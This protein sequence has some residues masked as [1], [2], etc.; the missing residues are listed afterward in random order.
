[1]KDLS[2]PGRIVTALA[3]IIFLASII[4]LADNNSGAIRTLDFIR[5]PAIYLAAVLLV[6]A[7]L[8][9]GRGLAPAA[10]LLAGSMAINF[11]SLWPYTPVAPEEL[12]L[13]TA[14]EDAGCMSLLA[15]NVLQDNEDYARTARLIERIDPDILF[16]TETNQAWIDAMEPQVA[17]YG[18][19]LDQP[20][21]NK[22]GKLFASKVPVVKAEYSDTF[23]DETPTLYATLRAPNGARFELIGLHPR[24]PMPG[25]STAKRDA[26]IAEA[27]QKTPDGLANVV[28]IGD[29]N[30]VPWSDTTQ[31]FR[32]L[33]DYSD[34][35][36]GRGSFATFPASYAYVG[37]PLD[38]FFV[39][40][41]VSVQDL[42]IGEEVG[43]DH[44]P[45]MARFCVD[46]D[47]R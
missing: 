19:R 9:L 43:S 25:R 13:G 4:S 44:L 20:L 8:V 2:I 46:H 18:Y 26:S 17:R 38:Q 37:W 12:P 5:E 15:F 30:D 14:S 39:K 41:K 35:R 21:D 34:P 42:E 36:A 24:P 16:L 28:A 47:G 11:W 23:D 32:A 29:F 31:N 10:G 3:A 27:G 33:G 22:Y 7:P 40:G 45:L 6:V 1:M